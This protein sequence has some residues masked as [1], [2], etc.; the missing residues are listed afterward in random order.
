MRGSG[1]DH[2]EGRF[3]GPNH[4]ET[5]GVFERNNIASAF[6]AIRETQ[7]AEDPDLKGKRHL[8]APFP[9]VSN[10]LPSM[11]VENVRVF[12]RARFCVATAP[13]A[14]TSDVSHWPR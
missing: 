14:M 4:E 3:Y 9:F 8:M 13:K 7:Q 12:A 1:P 2:I 6:G 11:S 10:V 5:G